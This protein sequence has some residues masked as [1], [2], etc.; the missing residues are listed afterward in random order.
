MEDF[1]EAEMEASIEEE[2][3]VMDLCNATIVEYWGITSEID[4]TF[5]HNVPIVLPQIILLKISHNCLQNV[6]QRT[7][8]HHRP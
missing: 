3:E 1:E 6:K 2:D 5:S 8:H 7:F 4:Q